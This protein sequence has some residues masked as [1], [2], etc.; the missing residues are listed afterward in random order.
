MFEL[1]MTLMLHWDTLL[2]H[3]FVHGFKYLGE[4]VLA[5]IPVLPTTSVLEHATMCIVI[6]DCIAI[7]GMLI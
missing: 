6:N 3:A 5:W 2:P 7:S 4:M 1:Y